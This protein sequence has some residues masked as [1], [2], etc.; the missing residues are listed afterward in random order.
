MRRSRGCTRFCRVR[1]PSTTTPPVPSLHG[2]SMSLTGIGCTAS[3]ATSTPVRR[4]TISASD[5]DT[6]VTTRARRKVGRASHAA[7]GILSS[8]WTSV[9][10]QVK[11]I[12]VPTG[13]A[14]PL[15]THQWACTTAAL[16]APASSSFAPAR[17]RSAEPVES[18]RAARRS[19]CSRH[20]SAIRESLLGCSA[21]SDSPHRHAVE[22]SI[23]PLPR[24]AR[25]DRPAGLHPSAEARSPA[26]AGT[27]R[28]HLLKTA[29]SCA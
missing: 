11:T 1:R 12:G 3:P 27:P 29:G 24:I 7:N 18:Q 15:G 8:S 23:A 20:R 26:G 4:C 28:Q 2:R 13:A 9:P 25:C 21:V 22:H 17:R 10:W 19:K 6:V 16:P 5:A 14:S